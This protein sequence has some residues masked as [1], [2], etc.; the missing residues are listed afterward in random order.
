[1]KSLVSRSA[2]QLVSLS[3]EI[4]RLAMLRHVTSSLIK[5]VAPIRAQASCCIP[6]YVISCRDNC[7]NCPPTQTGSTSYLCHDLCYGSGT[8]CECFAVSSCVTQCGG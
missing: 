6:C 3:T 8:F 1:M 5:F 4:A 2:D 7:A